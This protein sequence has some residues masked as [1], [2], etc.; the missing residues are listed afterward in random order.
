MNWIQVTI[1]DPC[2][3]TVCDQLVGLGINEFE[4]ED[5]ADF[6]DFVQ[7]QTQYWD[8][9]EQ[10]L[11]EDKAR[12]SCVKIYVPEQD[13]E[14]IQ[15]IVSHFG[16]KAVSCASMDDQDW[17]N[18][19]K[20][21][22]KPLHIGEH[23]VVCPCWE[24][25]APKAGERVITLD[26]GPAFGTGSHETT[27]MCLALMESAVQPG[28]CMLDIGCGSGILSI[29]ALTLGA[30]QVWGVDVDPIAVKVAGENGALNGFGSDRLH[31]CAG[32]LTDQIQGRFSL[33]TANIIADAII[34]L[35]SQVGDFL[36]PGG[37]FL[38][39]GIIADRAV[40][41]EQAL[42]SNGFVIE[43]RVQRKDWMAYLTRC[44]EKEGIGRA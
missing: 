42:L 22:Y 36:E 31:L 17:E 12:A 25:Y 4:I 10:E 8:I 33:I 15:L 13:R 39:S 1:T 23:L 24:E 18:A 38:C 2:P 29:A 40:D 11:Q 3:D 9:I 19:W 32:N 34:T 16:N 43:K 6:A 35:S 27:S 30:D 7:N 37:H 44:G 41:T 5:P 21:Y 26:P 20:Q 28:R 14:T